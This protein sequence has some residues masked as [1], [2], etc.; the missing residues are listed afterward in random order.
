MLLTPEEDVVM[1]ALSKNKIKK[2]ILFDVMRNNIE[3]IEKYKSM[4]IHL[5]LNYILSPLLNEN[6]NAILVNTSHDYLIASAVVNTI[7]HYRHLFSKHE[8]FKGMET[9]FICYFNNNYN[10]YYKRF[11]CDEYPNIKRRLAGAL[12]IV[13]IIIPYFP[14]ISYVAEDADS[15]VVA[16]H[17]IS[18]DQT[19]KFNLCITGD[20][21]WLQLLYQ[22]KTLFILM[23]NKDN[24]KIYSHKNFIEYYLKDKKYEC[25]NTIPPEM[26]PII[27]TYTGFIYRK[28]KKIKKI[29]PSKILK[30]IDQAI[31]SRSIVPKLYFDPY[32]V[33]EDSRLPEAEL[34]AENY[35][36]FL[37]F[38]PLQNQPLISLSMSK[39]IK[40]RLWVRKY[41]KDDLKILNTKYFTEEISLQLHELTEGYETWNSKIQW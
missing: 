8:F 36:K 24:T 3:G 35:K 32:T 11:E 41:A 28:Y 40:D 39:K 19:S 2:T 13:N 15:V 9:E 14:K 23:P 12:E 34:F 7:A 18:I 17:I 25:V 22:Y 30:V 33:L 20:D 5:D 4:T 1:R 10:S 21:T 27:Q 38:N 26:I 6:F 31:T 37:L 16:N 29:G